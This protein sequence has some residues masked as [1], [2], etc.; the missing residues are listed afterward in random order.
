MDKLRELLPANRVATIVGVVLAFVTFLTT[1]QTS[2]IPGSPG[3]EA[4]AKGIVLLGTVISALR[5]LEK[6]LEG[7]QN[8][9]SLL[10]SG[11]PKSGGLV[12]TSATAVGDVSEDYNPADQAPTTEEESAKPMPLGFET[13]PGARRSD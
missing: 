8:W 11:Q 6:F 3:A 2:F 5:L 9:D 4:I 1:I 13:Q 7:S 12:N 10:I